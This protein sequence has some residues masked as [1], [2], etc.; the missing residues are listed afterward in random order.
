MDQQE[1]AERYLA[2]W[3]EGN[4]SGIL[5]LTH[6]QVSYYDA[7]WG[8]ICS[9]QEFSKYLQIHFDTDFRWHRQDGEFLVTPNG[10]VIRYKAYDRNDKD[11][12]NPLYGGAEVLTFSAGLIMTISD[13]Y[14]DPD[15]QD[16][17]EIA[18]LA[19]RRHAQA[20]VAP[21][22]L[23]ARTSGRIKRQ[24]M[25][26]AA[27]Q[28]TFLNPSLTVTQLADHVGCSVMHLFHVLEEE[29]QTTFSE[30]V[31]EIRARYASSLLVESTDGELDHSH[32]ASQSGFDSATDFRQAFQDTFG[33]SPEDYSRKFAKT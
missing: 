22:G 19:E 21:L 11:G 2:A 7:F 32:I 13:F 4:V 29:K 24:L 33:D 27:A 16:L 9:G 30:F 26:L 23:S 31:N 18:T 14:C 28:T 10:L 17:L 15:P 3:D 6:P 8:E 12:V 5:K 25:K 1:L 20:N